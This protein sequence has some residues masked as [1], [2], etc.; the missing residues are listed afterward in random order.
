MLK[1]DDLVFLLDV[2]NTLFDNDQFAADLTAWPDEH[3]GAAER[4]RYWDIYATLRE[5]FG[6]VDY[7]ASLQQFRTG[8]TDQAALQKTSAFLLDYPFPKNIYPDALKAVAHMATLGTTTILS[9]GDIVFQP[10][11]VLRSG[12]A[13]VVGGRV[14][15]FV[16]KEESLDV[17]QQRFPAAH[18]VSVDDK[19]RLLIAIK[20]VLGDRV[21]TVFVRQGHYAQ[22]AVPDLAADMHVADITVEHIGDLCALTRA[23]FLLKPRGDAAA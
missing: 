12:L 5:Q 9:D 7:L 10:R 16:H 17:M 6:Y 21:T 14:L 18:Y 11:K 13:E 23:D 22:Q 8:I 20:R 2:D 1:T 15:I 19:P 4:Q 3:F